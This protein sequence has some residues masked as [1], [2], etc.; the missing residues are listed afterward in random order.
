M[1]ISGW[2]VWDPLRA[3]A[4]AWEW[5]EVLEEAW[6]E[7]WAVEWALKEEAKALQDQLDS[8]LSRIKDLE[9]R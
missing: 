2:D 4:A 6:V 8:I 5:E 7:E 3:R 9:E 1:H